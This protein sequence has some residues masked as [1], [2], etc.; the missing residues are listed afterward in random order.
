MS[1]LSDGIKQPLRFYDTVD[2]Q[3]F[4]Q[5]WVKDGLS[6]GY[7]LLVNPTNVIM[8][9]QLKRRRSV[10]TVTTFDLYTYNPIYSDFAFNLSIF[11][12]IDGPI[13]NHLR[14]VQNGTMDNIIWNPQLSFT[15][16]LDCGKHYI[17]VSDGISNWYS[18]VFQVDENLVGDVTR[19]ASVIP[20]GRGLGQTSAIAW[21]VGPDHT[22]LI[23]SKKPV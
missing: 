13:T 20:T 16:D 7:Q 12:I 5:S 1:A 22:T 17:H 4:R 21:Q 23:L 2:K 9:F 19:R 10:N 8:P 14:I 15:Q 11:S 6:D 3:N 18:E